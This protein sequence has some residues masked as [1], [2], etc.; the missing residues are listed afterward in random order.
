MFGAA[1]AVPESPQLHTL[2]SGEQGLPRSEATPWRGGKGGD[3]RRSLPSC[4]MQCVMQTV[5]RHTCP[6]Q[7]SG[8][9]HHPDTVPRSPHL[10]RSPLS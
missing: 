6:S 2:C 9:T 1:E 7:G 3:L 8:G 10:M 4:L 5:A